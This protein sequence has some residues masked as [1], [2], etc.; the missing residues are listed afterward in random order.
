MLKHKS[1]GIITATLQIRLHTLTRIHIHT[2]K[3]L[4]PA[5]CHHVVN[6][7][8][9]YLKLKLSFLP[10]PSGIAGCV[11]SIWKQRKYYNKPEVEQQHLF[12]NFSLFRWVYPLCKI[13]EVLFYSFCPTLV[14]IYTRIDIKMYDDILVLVL[15]KTFSFSYSHLAFLIKIITTW[16]IGANIP[17]FIIYVLLLFCSQQNWT[18]SL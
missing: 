10:S 18:N 11:L 15:D 12:R 17:F 7:Y 16:R 2:Y 14:Y 4:Y 9:L 13:N 1:V 3:K 8:I 5:F 6:F